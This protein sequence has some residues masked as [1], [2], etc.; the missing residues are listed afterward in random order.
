MVGNFRVFSGV[1]AIFRI[2]SVFSARLRP[3]KHEKSPILLQNRWISNRRFS[4]RVSK[5]LEIVKI[6]IFE[7]RIPYRDKISV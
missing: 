5:N 3:E 7:L 1:L 2:F 6:L 4:V